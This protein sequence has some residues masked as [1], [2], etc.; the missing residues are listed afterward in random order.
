MG[1]D[2]YCEIVLGNTKRLGVVPESTELAPADPASGGWPR[3]VADLR[4]PWR[5]LNEEQRQLCNRDAESYAG[6]CSYNDHQVGRLL[7]YLEEAAPPAPDHQLAARDAGR[8]R[9]RA[10][11]VPS[12]G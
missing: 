7:D 12:R 5:S 4:Q 10:R 6:L 1:Y 2:R 11:S 8:N 9:R 3:S